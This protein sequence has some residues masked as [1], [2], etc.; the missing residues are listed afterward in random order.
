[1]VRGCTFCLLSAWEIHFLCVTHFCFGVACKAKLVCNEE[2]CFKTVN[3]SRGS[4]DKNI[5]FEEE[6]KQKP[7]AACCC[8]VLVFVFWLSHPEAVSKRSMESL[9]WE[10]ADKQQARY[11]YAPIFL[12]EWHWGNTDTILSQQ[13]TLGSYL[14]VKSGY[15]TGKTWSGLAKSSFRLALS[16]IS[17][18]SSLPR[19]KHGFAE[20][21]SH[22][23]SIKG[24]LTIETMNIAQRH[25]VKKGIG[26]RSAPEKNGFWN[27]GRYGLWKFYHSSSV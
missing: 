7:C 3:H 12:F 27:F 18:G 22:Y 13:L 5:Y 24:T 21:Q 16:S 11:F 2:V 10:I 15:C 6:R 26:A 19:N 23:F 4:S 20:I 9:L 8:T 17:L 1:M 14:E 25:S